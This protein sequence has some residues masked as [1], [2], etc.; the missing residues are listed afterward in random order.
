M[1]CWLM[2]TH[3]GAISAL[4]LDDNLNEFTFRFNRR[5]LASRGKLFQRLA[6]RAVQLEPVSFAKLVRW[7]VSSGNRWTSSLEDF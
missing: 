3:Q 4:H 1:K 5:T 7:R 6:Q 2:G